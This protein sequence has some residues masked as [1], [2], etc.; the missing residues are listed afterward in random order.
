MSCRGV[1]QGTQGGRGQSLHYFLL[2]HFVCFS[3]SVCRVTNVLLVEKQTN[4]ETPIFLIPQPCQFEPGKN[5]NPSEALK[6]KNCLSKAFGKLWL[7]SLVEKALSVEP[8]P[9]EERGLGSRACCSG[10]GPGVCRWGRRERETD[11]LWTQPTFTETN[12]PFTQRQ[13]KYL[14]PRS[15]L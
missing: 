1:T 7:T 9:P 2:I 11:G 10:E 8:V 14:L 6:K 5:Q 13:S 12:R 3:Q 4:G 15:E